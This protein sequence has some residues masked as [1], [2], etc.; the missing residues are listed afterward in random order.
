MNIQILGKNVEVTE[1]ISARINEALSHLDRYSNEE[2]KAK[3]VI[4]TYHI[5]QK[6]EIALELDKSH[7]LRQEAVD[8]DLYLAI[9]VAAEK[10]EEQLRRIKDR[11]HNHNR[12]EKA[13]LQKFFLEL[14]HEPEESKAIVRRKEVELKPMSEEEAILQFE[15][16]GHDFYVFEDFNTDQVKVLYNRKDGE[17]GILEF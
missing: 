6:I 17:Y 4:K 14:G 9:D 15:L 1:G 8:R 3:V 13:E 16:V 2:L 7:T 5:G 10:L 11:L 12:S